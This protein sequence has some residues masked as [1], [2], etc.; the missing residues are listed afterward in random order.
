VA[1]SSD[2]EAVA[3]GVFEEGAEVWIMTKKDF[4]D[5]DE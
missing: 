3:S 2:T 4:S 1:V 5:F